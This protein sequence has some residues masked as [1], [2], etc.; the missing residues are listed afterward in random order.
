MT[1]DHEDLQESEAAEIHVERF[2]RQEVFVKEEYEFSCANRTLGLQGV[3]SQPTSG[4]EHS[5]K[6]LEM[7]VT[8]GAVEVL[9][10]LQRANFFSGF[11]ARRLRHYSSHSMTYLDGTSKFALLDNGEHQF[12]S[13]F[14]LQT[15]RWLVQLQHELH[16]ELHGHILELLFR[17][18]LAGNSKRVC[19]ALATS[20]D[21]CERLLLL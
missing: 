16:H 21:N 4:V 15:V 6:I 14:A 19:L 7:L 10:L 5:A 20:S 1:A 13:A 3:Q 11:P 18:M 17:R 8:F 12:L 2:K 9:P